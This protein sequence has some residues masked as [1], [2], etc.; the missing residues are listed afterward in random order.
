MSGITPPQIF[1]RPGAYNTA[2]DMWWRAPIN[3]GGH[4]ISGYT[5]TCVD[6]TFSTLYLSSTTNEG[7]ITGLRSYVP[8]TFQLT[9]T[10]INADTSAAATFRTVRPG[11]KTSAPLRPTASMAGDGMVTLSWVTPYVGGNLGYAVV[12]V[13]GSGTTI[14]SSAGPTETSIVVAAD[15]SK[16]YACSIYSVNDSGWSVPTTVSVNTTPFVPDVVI[17][18]AGT[19][20]T[21]TPR[22][23]ITA[24]S[25][26]WTV[27]SI[28][29]GSTTSTMTY[30]PTVP[31]TYT[32]EATVNGTYTASY[33]AFNPG[34][35][36]QTSGS[37]VIT[38]TP[39]PFTAEPL[40][41]GYGPYT[42]AWSITDGSATN[43]LG[44]SQNQTLV[45]SSV[46]G[47]TSPYTLN[48]SLGSVP[49]YTSDFFVCC[50]TNIS[51][52][53]DGINWTQ[54]AS[55]NTLV[56]SG[57]SQCV[58][59]NGSRWVAGGT[60]SDNSHNILIYSDDGI[61]W[62]AS[63]NGNDIFTA[64]GR[65]CNSVAWNGSLWIA[66]GSN[67]IAYSTDGITWTSSS[68]GSGLYSNSADGFASNGVITV[69]VGGDASSFAA[70]S[71]DGNTWTPA[72]SSNILGAQG[73][74]TGIA[75]NGIMFVAGGTL[76][77]S[78][79]GINW[80]A[81]ANGSSVFTGLYGVS[82]VTWTG[83]KWVAVGRI[84][85]ILGYSYDGINWFAATTDPFDNYTWA[86][87]SGKSIVVAGE[88]SDTVSLAY[89]RDGISWTANPAARSVVGSV[90]GLASKNALVKVYTNT[91]SG[92]TS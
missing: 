23:G 52:S 50:G 19:T 78:Y 62:T 22:A 1:I 4:D 86:V 75:C 69:V 47:L 59:Y 27:N 17:T 10:N 14:K 44:M 61:T 80:T 12:L 28:A 85:D 11:P 39:L 45:T 91:L 35:G 16:T 76:G 66:G 21:V 88:Q 58:A 20:F 81:S 5:L 89:S 70:Y 63:A 18:Q 46:S 41:A 57:M 3:S 79:D 82:E 87:A 49:S 73:N 55:A 83:T 2:I 34:V 64:A 40:L 77:Y 67:K 74:C 68:S 31:G 6:Q 32:V 43:T 48:V 9:A 56:A 84:T 90:V 33:L 36:I 54:S 29:Q 8:Y 38:A 42:Y 37:T 30:T 51:Y 25:W 53:Y 65:T 60:Y 13:P 15:S 7:Y 26:A 71:Y 24:T 92:L 72:A